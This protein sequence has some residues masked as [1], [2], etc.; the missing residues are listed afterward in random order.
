VSLV[1]AMA[2]NRVIGRDNA[3]PWHLPEDLRHFRELTL[4]KPVVMGRLTHESIGR[5]LPGR[6]NIV[7]SASPG[8]TP[9]PGAIRVGSIAAALE[10]A[11]AICRRD[12][13]DECM[14]IGGAR[15][16]AACLPIAQRIYLTLIESEVDGDTWFPEFDVSE[17][18]ETSRVT[19]AS[20]AD[21][22]MRFCFV[23]L[24]K[25]AN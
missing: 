2:R 18:Q 13:V 6:D 25:S 20:A 23:V 22:R 3:L 7:V 15:I 1:V 17:W 21:A 8:Y 9:A 4:G 10:S 19:A 5:A 11:A 16:Y 12:G 14:V 24:E